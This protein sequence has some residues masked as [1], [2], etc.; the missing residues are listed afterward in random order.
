MSPT[1]FGEWLRSAR[2]AA[3]TSQDALAEASGVSQ[4]TIS[5]LERGASRPEWSTLDALCRALGLS[6]AEP[7][8]LI[9]LALPSADPRS[10][11]TAGPTA[12]AG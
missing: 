10:E 11:E 6:P 8:K 9:A 3:G 4:G 1:T 12:A 2:K 7:A 5:N